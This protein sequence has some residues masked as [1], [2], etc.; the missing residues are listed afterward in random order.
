MSVTNV[1]KNA[2][3]SK[4]G[5]LALKFLG[6]FMDINSLDEY[7]QSYFFKTNFSN[8]HVCKYRL[9]IILSNDTIIRLAQCLESE[10]ELNVFV[11]K[12]KIYLLFFL[13]EGK[14]EMIIN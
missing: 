11:S 8:R 1:K 10:S 14:S 12:H 6:K 3:H 9:R 7:E 13:K 2:S 5:E 4:L